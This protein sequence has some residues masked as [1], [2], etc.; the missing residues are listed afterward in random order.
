MAHVEFDIASR[1]PPE[2]IIAALT[3]F[4]DRRPELWPGLN[5]KEY[6]VHASG[7]TWADVREGNGGPIW[8][9][10]RYDW[11]QP[12]NVTWT[13][14]ESG[15]ARPDDFVSVDVAPDGSGG[16]RLHV[17]WTRHGANLIG[18]A[19]VALIRLTGGRPVRSA[20]EAGLQRIAE[21]DASSPSPPSHA[22]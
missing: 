16:S 1:L 8:A 11:S 15:F 6:R 5:P 3:D 12:G 7:D 9:R 17:A 20:I 14:Q 10:E 2:R 13:V 18:A 22:S 4:S 19:V 21:L